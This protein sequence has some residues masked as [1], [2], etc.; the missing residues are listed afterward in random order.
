[1]WRKEKGGWQEGQEDE[2]EEGDTEGRRW[3]R[4]GEKRARKEGKIKDNGESKRRQGQ[5]RGGDS[6]NEDDEKQIIGE[7]QDKR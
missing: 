1:M 4:N 6:Q 7:K 3:R 5:N 2:G